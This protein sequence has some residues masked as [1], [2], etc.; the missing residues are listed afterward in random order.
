MSNNPNLHNNLIRGMVFV[1]AFLAAAFTP[2]MFIVFWYLFSQVA[3]VSLNESRFLKEIAS[4]FIFSFAIS[5][6]HV[7][8]L[9]APRM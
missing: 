8:V 2:A 4:V 6:A 7:V 5:T 1:L 9:G 3:V